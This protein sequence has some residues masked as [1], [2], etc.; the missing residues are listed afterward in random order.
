MCL[1]TSLHV[2]NVNSYFYCPRYSYVYMPFKYGMPI[3]STYMRYNT[4][5]RGVMLNALDSEYSDPSSCLGGTCSLRKR[6]GQSAYQ[7][8]T[9]KPNKKQA[10]HACVSIDGGMFH[11]FIYDIEIMC[12]ICSNMCSIC[13]QSLPLNRPICP[14]RRGHLWKDQVENVTNINSLTSCTGVQT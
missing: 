4:S 6:N 1:I 11:F 13:N 2:F 5:S 12:S 7:L 14:M 3:I 9:M 10:A 8:K